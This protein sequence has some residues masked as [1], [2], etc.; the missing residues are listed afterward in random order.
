ML[1]VLA[2]LA[3]EQELIA[4]NSRAETFGGDYPNFEIKAKVAA[5]EADAINRAIRL[6]KAMRAHTDVFQVAT[7]IPTP[8]TNEP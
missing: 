1:E 4:L 6:L 8:P 5:Q 7:P 2:S 3:F